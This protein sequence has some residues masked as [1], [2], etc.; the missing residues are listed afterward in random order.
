MSDRSFH[1]R[2][3]YFTGPDGRQITSAQLPPSCARALFPKGKVL[4]V[5]AVRHGLISVEE[6]C[7]RYRLSTDEYLSLQRSIDEASTPTAC[8]RD[9]RD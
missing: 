3:A 9:H 8:L 7:E 1:V 6:A 4:V 5:E 2:S